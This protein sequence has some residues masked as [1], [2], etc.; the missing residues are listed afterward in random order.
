MNLGPDLI[1]GFL[2]DLNISMRV[3][4]TTLWDIT[5]TGQTVRRGQQNNSLEYQ[6]Q[7]NQQS[8][9]ETILQCLSIRC[10]PENI[11]EVTKIKTSRSTWGTEY[12]NAK[13]AWT[14]T[15]ECLDDVYIIENDK[16]A[17]LYLDCDNVPLITGLD[18]TVNDLKTISN[19]PELKNI[20]FEI[21]L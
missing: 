15:F 12:K 3:A 11:S 21:I 20:H 14:F 18:E 1:L 9:W 13:I 10:Q 17:G 6:K 16:L 5:V 7:C 4:C 8:N 19:S 2:F